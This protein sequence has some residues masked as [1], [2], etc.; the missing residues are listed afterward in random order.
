MPVMKVAAC[1]SYITVTASFSTEI[2]PVRKI[3]QKIAKINC[4][5]KQNKNF[6]QCSQCIIWSNFKI[7]RRFRSGALI[8]NMCFCFF[9]IFLLRDQWMTERLSTAMGAAFFGNNLSQ[10]YRKF[11]PS[12]PPKLCRSA[13]P[14]ARPLILQSKIVF[15]NSLRNRL[16][17]DWLG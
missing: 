2:Q 17:D 16:P 9:V 1:A 13:A 14:R 4:S 10:F 8:R 15:W 12:D 7:G 5:S 11:R 3:P 6:F